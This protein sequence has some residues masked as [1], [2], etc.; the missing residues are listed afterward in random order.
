MMRGFRALALAAPMLVLVLVACGGGGGGGSSTPAFSTAITGSSRIVANT[1]YD[2][3]ATAANGAA[4]NYQWA[5]GDGSVTNTANPSTSRAWNKPGSYNTQLTA[6]SSANSTATDSMTNVVVATPVTLGRSHACAIQ[7][8]LTVACWGDNL[9][10]QLGIGT[11]TNTYAGQVPNLVPGLTNIVALGSHGGGTCALN[12]TGNVFCWGV[13]GASAL[14]TGS[15]TP[16]LISGFSDVVAIT[17]G[18]VHMCA[19]KNDGT[20]WCWGYGNIA[21]IGQGID[22]GPPTLFPVKVLNLT[23]VT[24]VVSGTLANHTCAIKSNKTVVCWGSNSNGQSGFQSSLLLPN[25]V[26]TNPNAIAV[27]DVISLSIIENTSC[28]VINDGAM[29]C[30]GTNDSGQFG[31][32]AGGGNNY[33]QPGGYNSTPTLSGVSNIAS[34]AI[35]YPS[36][37]IKMNQTMSCWGNT[38]H[39]QSAIN[40][41]EPGEVTIAQFN[42]VV[43]ISAGVSNLQNSNS[44]ALLFGGDLWCRGWNQSGQLGNGTLAPPGVSDSVTFTQVAQLESPTHKVIANGSLHSCAVQTDSTVVCWGWGALGQV[45]INIPRSSSPVLVAGTGGAPVLNGVNS[46]AAGQGHNCALKNDTTVVCWGSGSDGQLGSGLNGQIIGTGT[47]KIPVQVSGIGGIG[48]LTGVKSISSN[49]NH[50]C[51]L[52]G[53]TGSVVCWGWGLQGQLGNGVS[54]DS[55]VP[56]LVSNLSGVSE[57]AVGNS[58]TCALKVADGTISC[59][60]LGSFGQLGNGNVSNSNV[61]VRVRDQNGTA[62][63]GSFR[64]LAAGFGHNCAVKTNGD[65]MCWGRNNNGQLGSGSYVDSNTAVQ[66]NNLVVNIKKVAAGSAQTCVI[67]GANDSVKCWGGNQFGE[68][69]NS[70]NNASLIA[71]SVSSLQNVR[72]I[73]TVS[74]H[75]CALKRRGSVW[76]W[77]RGDEGQLGGGTYTNSNFPIQ[78]IG[79]QAMEY[80]IA[81]TF[82][83]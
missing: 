4:I 10:G 61:P 34:V 16:Q 17:G 60:G 12:A 33:N 46:I 69:G 28:A 25:G 5:W 30:W 42:N 19:L 76:C 44:C 8:D 57:I 65:M 40:H 32:G 77:G 43:A 6:T 47:N 2:Y 59:W 63:S 11:N 48:Q 14:N 37:A 73:A 35:G 18:S 79:L 50:T 9:K 62:L 29:K 68:L 75:N 74:N 83:K 15:N 45:G 1:R 41:P 26:S 81:P 13:V 67:E 52:L 54:V 82:W 72:E 38:T 27:T 31:T 64:S 78:V 51:A 53:L 58:S 24:A 49:A 55:N 36:C 3:S 22:S 71:T 39:T 80:P 23:G 70:T 66:S 20:V 7:S 21:Q 56:V